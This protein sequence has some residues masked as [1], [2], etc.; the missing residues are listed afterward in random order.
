MQSIW[1]A[2]KKTKTFEIE[3]FLH[4]NLRF[5]HGSKINLTQNHDTVLN[6]IT[7]LLEIQCS[8]LNRITLGQPKSDNNKQM[9]QLTDANLST[10][11]V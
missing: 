8:P 9:I 5:F 3:I 11:K 10:V 4:L 7:D 2:Q 6:W 1:Y